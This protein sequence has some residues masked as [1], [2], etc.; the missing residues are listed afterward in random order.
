MMDSQNRVI[1]IILIKKFVI[2]TKGNIH[3]IQ[4]NHK[5]QVTMKT[6]VISITQ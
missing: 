6:A 4:A 2:L 1:L 5:P 3:T